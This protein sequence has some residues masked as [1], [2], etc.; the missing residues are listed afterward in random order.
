[1]TREVAIIGPGRVGTAIGVLARQGGYRVTAVG[2][3]DLEKTRRAAARIGPGVAAESVTAAAAGARLVLLTVADDA[4]T[5]VAGELAASGVLKGV[6]VLAHCSG[7]LPGEALAVARDAA[8]CAVGSAHPLQTFPSVDGAL[9]RLPGAFWVYEGDAPAWTPLLELGVD[10]GLRP[11]RIASAD[12]T[13][14]HAMAVMASNYLVAL[15]DAA[16]TLGGRVGMDRGIAWEALKPLVQATLANIDELG[17]ASALT[18]P[19]QRGDEQTVRRHLAWLAAEPALE[20]LY[21][22][23]GVRTAAL[24]LEAGGVDE[25]AAK[26]LLELLAEPGPARR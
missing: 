24:A 9:A 23:L 2:G 25:D 26:R 20:S 7:A 19:I 15:M 4:I 3:R 21:R 18:G 1:M 10:M 11:L 16:L 13:G 14:Y 17:T 8:G 22:R 12:K 6:E 5:E